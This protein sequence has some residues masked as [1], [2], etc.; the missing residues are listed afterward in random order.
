M[1]SVDNNSTKSDDDGISSISC[2]ILNDTDSV[3]SS[4]IIQH[5]FPNECNFN[6]KAIVNNHLNEEELITCFNCY[7]REEGLSSL[8]NLYVEFNNPYSVFSKDIIIQLLEFIEKIAVNETYIYLNRKH[9]EYCNIKILIIKLVKILKVLRIVGFNLS[10]E[11]FNTEL[12]RVLV[13]KK[14]N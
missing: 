6:L 13:L 8:L 7:Y 12:Y 5:P 11:G 2:S 14:R 10:E 1:S 9:T 3:C 4:P